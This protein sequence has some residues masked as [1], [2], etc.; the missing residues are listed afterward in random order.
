MCCL[1]EG[2]ISLPEDGE[3][4]ELFRLEEP[5]KLQWAS[6]HLSAGGLIIRKPSGVTQPSSPL[7]RQALLGGGEISDTTVP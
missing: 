5:V 4:A 1:Q 6:V 2:N 3:V 7:I